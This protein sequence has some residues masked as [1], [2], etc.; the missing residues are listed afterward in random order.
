MFN[1]DVWVKNNIDKS[2]QPEHYTF[3]IYL[4]GS[5]TSTQYRCCGFKSKCQIYNF[6]DHISL[7]Y[8][9][10]QLSSYS[11]SGRESVRIEDIT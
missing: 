9:L 4:S 1:S 6:M 3:E 11:L 2:C 7:V 5:H 8:C 10:I